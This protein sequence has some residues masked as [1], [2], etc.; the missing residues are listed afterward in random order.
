MFSALNGWGWSSCLCRL[1]AGR[2]LCLHFGWRRWDFCLWWAGLCEVVCFWVSV[3]SLLMMV[4]FVFLSFLLFGWDILLLNGGKL[5]VFPLRLGRRQK[6]Q[7]APLLF[8]INF[9]SPTHC[10]LR[11][12]ER[13]PDWK[14]KKEDS[15]CLQ[16]KWYRT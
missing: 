6:C 12:N 10:N 7:F 2:D 8:N 11:R 14:N 1:H 5:K 4:T 3:E 16:M 15:H 13:N 9:G